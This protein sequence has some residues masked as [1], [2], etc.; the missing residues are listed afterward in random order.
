MNQTKQ[1]FDDLDVNQ[2]NIE[3]LNQIE[4]LP[5][6][7]IKYILAITPRSGSSFFADVLSKTKVLGIPREFLS[8]GI[9]HHLSNKV[10]ARTP[11]EYLKNVVK[12]WQTRNKVCGIK[13]SWFQF[14]NLYD[15]LDNKAIISEYRYIYLTR[16]NLELQAV[17]LYK[18]TESNLFHSIAKHKQ[19]SLEKL[20]KLEYDFEKI[21]YWYQHIVVQEQ[22]WEDFF[23]LNDIQPLC[24]TYED[25]ESNWR[26]LVK[27]VG[28]FVGLKKL[29]LNKIEQCLSEIQP[30]F[31]KIGDEKNIEW[32]NRFTQQRT[33]LLLN[34]KN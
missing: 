24:I 8:Q 15:I 12:V 31:E 18:A 30:R 27:Q 11:D 20:N 9:L 29:G 7:S 1:I 25:I 19:E 32:A 14:R 23:S 26:F 22:G 21:N 16:S 5:N 13:A 10:P 2:I 4:L 17:S 34:S 28:I 6:P 33:E 3:L